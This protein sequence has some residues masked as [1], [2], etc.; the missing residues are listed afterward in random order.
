MRHPDEDTIGANEQILAR[1][2]IVDARASGCSLVLPYWSSYSW[3]WGV[4]YVGYGTWTRIVNVGSEELD[5]YQA[6]T[7]NKD[8]EEITENTKLITLQ[9]GESYYWAK[10]YGD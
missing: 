3:L 2:Y 10:Q 1:E 5:I 9:P 7:A 6:P 8:D 4:G